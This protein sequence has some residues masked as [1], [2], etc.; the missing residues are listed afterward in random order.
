MGVEKKIFDCRKV[1]LE[2]MFAEGSCSCEEL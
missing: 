1:H 2:M